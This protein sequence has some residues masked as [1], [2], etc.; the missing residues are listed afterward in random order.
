MENKQ[1]ITAREVM[2]IWG[3]KS[4]K[5]YAIIKAANNELKARGCYVVS[6]KAPR[7]FVLEKLGLDFDTEN[8]E[9]AH[10]QTS[11]RA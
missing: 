7:R 8:D 1:Y 6:G 11:R 4:T 5:A 2:E 3:I 9:L 10:L